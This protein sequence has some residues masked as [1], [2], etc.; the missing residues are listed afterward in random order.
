MK[1]DIV[2]CITILTAAIL[3]VGC[4]TFAKQGTAT[5][6]TAYLTPIPRETLDAYQWD[7][8]VRNKMDAVIAARLSLDTTRL[9]YTEEPKVVLA[10]EMRFDDARRRVAQPGFLN[11]I[12]TEEIPGDANV[13]LV[14]FEGDWQM[15]GPPPEEPVTP[16][17]PSHGC[18]YII[19]LDPNDLMR[20][21]FGTTKCSP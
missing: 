14:L 3:M 11:V 12:N 16:E 6:D 21:Q 7:T 1:S 2:Y 15:T 9:E 18:V 5:E 8:P 13:W 17:P 10:E 4:S 20:T 19:I